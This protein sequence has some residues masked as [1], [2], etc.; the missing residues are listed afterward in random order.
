MWTRKYLLAAAA[1]AAIWSMAAGQPLASTTAAKASSGTAAPQATDDRQ[2]LARADAILAQMT[3][4]EKV[5]QLVQLFKLPVLPPVDDKVRSG[6]VGSLLFITDPAEANRLQRIAMTE[7][8]LKIPLL[9]GFD[10]LHGLHTIF[11][12]PLGMAA[13]FDPDIAEQAQATAAREARA[14]GI[15]W[16]FGPM[17][18]VARDPRW[19]RMVEG[20]G[21]DPFLGA[22]MARAQ[23]RGFQGPRI[24]TPGRVIA[25]PK[26]FVGYGASP[27]GR[28]YDSIFVSDAELYNVYLS[29]FAAAIDAGA[30][31]VM[32]AYMDLND[33]P[34]SA[35][36]RLLTDILR[37]EL[38]FKGW[39]VSDAN[40]INSQVKQHFAAD[41]ADAAVRAIKAGND[42]EMALAQSAFS[43]LVDSVK[44]GK[45]PIETIDRSVRRIL[46]AKI[47]LGLFERPYA[48]EAEAKRILADPVHRAVAKRAAERSLVLLRNE[49]GLLPLKPGTH[50]KVAV[51]GPMADSPDDTVG[52][53]AF[54]YDRDE[55]VTL[56]EGVRDRLGRGASVQTA[57]G[58][59]LARSFPSGLE[60]FQPPPPAWTTERS[61]AEFKQAI[62]LANDSDLIVLALG[63]ARN[64]SGERASASDLR[65]PGEQIKLFEAVVAT[66]KP[67]VVVLMNGR[68]LDL[69]G[70]VDR[71]PAILE[72]WYPGTRG[73]TALARA[74]FGDINPGGKLPVT[75]PRNVGQV[76]IFYAHNRSQAPE[77]QHQRYYDQPSSPLFPFGHGLSYTRFA[78]SGL[79][80]PAG[81]NGDE[82]VTVKVTLRNTGKRA[83]KEV[84][85]I[86]VAPLAPGAGDPP[87][88]LRGFAKIDLAPGARR[89]VSVTLDPRSFSQFDAEQGKWRI[90]PGRYRIMAGSS[91]A[92]TRQQREIDVTAD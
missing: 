76:P 1:S 59:Q 43:T 44:T 10:V 25:G 77:T 87:I 21:E 4:E 70:I 75:W 20:A 7:S 46:T 48:D 81:V 38:G 88:A 24:G 84:V 28:D 49:G 27:G 35:S 56:F 62:D 23:V 3:V 83:G 64:Q 33:V 19:G 42:M 73:G 13:S 16:T 86:Y 41:P 15:G 65:L 61:A 71:A 30:G 63:E 54:V 68:P 37:G 14:V 39:V 57:A 78:Y 79:S 11:P 92:D 2:V 69:T 74:L 52:P 85:Q 80:A 67:F 51:I 45:L 55:T 5:G 6:Q 58:V 12:V 47:A 29:P 32:S 17:I 82:M 9:F 40:A 22:A 89:T 36:H 26:H 53:W 50:K 18:D 66:G 90:V 60:M 72:G 34:A 91:S 8:R 31:N